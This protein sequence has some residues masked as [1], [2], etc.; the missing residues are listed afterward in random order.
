MA[1]DYDII[2]TG[3]GIAGSSCAILCARAGLSVLLLERGERPGSKNLS[4]GRIYPYALQEILPGFTGHAPLERRICRE[5]ISLLSIDSAT[6]FSS[7]LAES[8][9]WSLLRGRFDPWLAEQAQAAG[10]QLL[11]S[12]TVE[13]LHIVDERVCGVVCEGETISARYVVLAEGANSLLAEQHQL[14]SRP[15]P[16]AMALG[17]KEVLA[18]DRSLIEE[19][20]QLEDNQGVAWLFS[21]G[22]CG[23]KPGGAFLYTNQE[24]L[25]FGVVCPLASLGNQ[26]TA[27]AGLLTN[28]KGH[29]MLRPLLRRAES[30]EYGAHLVPEGGLHGMPVQ[31]G[32]DGW[33]LIGDALGACINTGFTIRGMDLAVLS[34]QAA[35]QTLISACQSTAKTS[36]FSDY[37][38]QLER[39]TLWSVLQRYQAHPSLLQHAQWYQRWPDFCRDLSHALWNVQSSPTPP[40]WQLLWHN[41]RKHGMRHLVTDIFRSFR[42]L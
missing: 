5:N 8:H 36:L 41:A 21:G 13:K 32:G 38:Q 31:K 33:L 35:A 34:A 11:S 6:T 42:C 18:L 7:Q 40:L 25:S 3:A 14:I 9:S 12:V 29:P 15:S 4:G 19:R 39:S 27:A 22:V 24:T 2:I 23:D 26:P 20:F 30:I 16:H 10:A 17:I 37:H 28:L 1:D